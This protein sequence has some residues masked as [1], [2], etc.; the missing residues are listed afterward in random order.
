MIIAL[1]S[2]V[3]RRSSYDRGHEAIRTRSRRYPRTRFPNPARRVP[4]RRLRDH[5]GI[6]RDRRRR[7]IP[8]GRAYVE[9]R[10]VAGMLHRGQGTAQTRR[11][12]RRAPSRPGDAE[13]RLQ[14]GA[15]TERKKARPRPSPGASGR[16]HV[17]FSNSRSLGSHR[18]LQNDGRDAGV[19]CFQVVEAP[20]RPAEI[21]P[22]TSTPQRLGGRGPAIGSPPPPRGSRRPGRR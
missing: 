2:S 22:P 1:R 16:P 20:E 11:R 3:S 12:P 14:P 17:S 7:A 6:G 18:L 19:G 10:E 4:Y 9:G 21:M 13:A 15:A 5:A 8:T